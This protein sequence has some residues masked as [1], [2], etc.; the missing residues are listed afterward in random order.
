MLLRFILGE[1]GSGKSYRIREEFLQN[2]E[3]CTELDTA[4][5]EALTGQIRFFLAY[6]YI[7]LVALYGDV[8]L[9]EKVLTEEESKIQTRTPKAEVLAFA[10]GQLDQ[11]IKELDGKALGKGRVTAGACK[12]LKARAYLWENDYSNLLAVT[13][14]LIGKYSLNTA[15]ETP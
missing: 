2:I 8:P 5:K 1:A 4:E 10:H 6:S 7:R 11:A 14:E 3:K 15:G 9:V 13:S 12:A